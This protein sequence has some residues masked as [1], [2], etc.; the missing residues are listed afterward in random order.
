[1]KRTNKAKHN[2]TANQYDDAYYGR[3]ANGTN[4]ATTKT[5]GE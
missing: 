3:K 2:R 4:N 1:M 5:K